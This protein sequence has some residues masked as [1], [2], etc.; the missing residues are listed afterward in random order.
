VRHHGLAAA[1]QA[2][3]L[4]AHR[5]AAAQYA[6]VAAFTRPD[7][8]ALLTAWAYEAY[9]TGNPVAAAELYGRAAALYRDAGDELRHGDALRWVS[10][11]SWY[12][13]R[14]ADA[15][16]SGA[17]AV[18]VLAALPP[19]REL[20]AAWSNQAQLAMLASDGATAIRIASQAIALARE[21]G[22][23]EIE[24]RAQ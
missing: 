14:R 8:P 13:G 19:S 6:R 9:L 24:A 15:D 23:A 17:R 22:D 16:A 3:A 4:R 10:R 2:V 20:A 1:R 18:E 11:V 12:A 7:D 21:L 5:E